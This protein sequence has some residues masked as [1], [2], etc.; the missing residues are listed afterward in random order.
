MVVFLRKEHSHLIEVDGVRCEEDSRGI[1][2]EEEEE[3]GR[4]GRK[5][6]NVAVI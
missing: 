2:E 6:M 4:G 3:K 5:V 1:E